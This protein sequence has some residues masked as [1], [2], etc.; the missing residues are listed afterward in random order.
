[1]SALQPGVPLCLG[2]CLFLAACPK[3]SGTGSGV[4]PASGSLL[5]DPVVSGLS[6]PLFL[7]APA[8]DPRLFI[9]EQPGRIRVVENGALLPAP[10]LD[11]SGQISSGGER[12]LLGLAFHPSYGSNKFFYVYFTA[13][14]GDITITR[15]AAS[16]DPNVADAGSAHPIITAAHSSR[17]NHNG[18]M[19][20]FGADGML[21][22]GTGDGGGGGDPDENGQD[23]GTLLGKLLRLDV[24]AGDPY[25]IPADN[26]FVGTAGARGEIWAIGLRNPW[27]WAFDRTAG[28]LYIADVGQSAWEEVNVTAATAAGVNYGWDVMEG[29]HCYEPSS[30]CNPSGLAQPVLEYG[31]DEG[32]SITGGLVYR[33]AAVPALQGTYFYADYCGGWVRSFRYANN[34]AAE[35]QEWAFGNLGNIL[36]F[37]EDAAGELYI[38]SANGT[39]YRIV[40]AP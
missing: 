14:N 18:G 4:P 24:D 2:L 36:S 3:D 26:P 8:T 19:L 15:Y 28:D 13:P 16:A 34:S 9:V 32:C 39:V 5:A 29:R 6:N 10:F 23:P 25:A 33:G 17:T 31:H 20:A 40:P 27:R 11:L 22:I 7:T 30:G 21:Y 38:L 37:G 12:G 35:P 1:M